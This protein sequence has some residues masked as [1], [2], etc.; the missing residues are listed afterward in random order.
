MFDTILADAGITVVHRDVQMPRMN[1]IIER[2]VRTC[3]RELLDRTFV[4]D[5]TGAPRYGVRTPGRCPAT[6]PIVSAA[7]PG[8]VPRRRGCASRRR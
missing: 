4:L 2:W 3:R 8:R 7:R 6:G 5:D 1:A